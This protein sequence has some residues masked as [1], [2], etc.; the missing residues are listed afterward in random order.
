MG[1]VAAGGILKT[2]ISTPFIW[3]SWSLPSRSESPDPAC[4]PVEV[5]SEMGEWRAHPQG[6]LPEFSLPEYPYDGARLR[7]ATRVRSTQGAVQ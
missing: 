2:N 1:D 5:L 4:G 6:G 3:H 7:L